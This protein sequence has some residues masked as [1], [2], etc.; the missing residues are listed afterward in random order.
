M[1]SRIHNFIYKILYFKRIREEVNHTLLVLFVS[2]GI[3]LFAASLLGPLYALYVEHLIRDPFDISLSVAV[4]LFASTMMTFILSRKQEIKSKKKL[5][6]FSYLTRSIV[7]LL[8]IFINRFELLILAQI[9]LGLADSVGIN[10]FSV[11][12][13]EHLN[14]KRKAKDYAYWNMIASPATAIAILVGGAF[15][16]LFGFKVLFVMMSCLAL[17]STIIVGLQPDHFF[18]QETNV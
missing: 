10:M 6:M 12:F 9:I 7:W 4:A 15:V 1:P 8:F 5:L 14:E 13:A 3:F 2:N 17:T 18:S 16:G 11:I